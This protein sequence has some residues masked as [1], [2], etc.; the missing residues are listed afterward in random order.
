MVPR[1]SGAQCVR[2]SATGETFY[3][4]INCEAIPV[5]GD[6]IILRM[7]HL[8]T[9]VLATVER[10][11]VDGGIETRTIKGAEIVVT[12]GQITSGEILIDGKVSEATRSS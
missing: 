1:L 11:N 12:A 9:D 6:W 4:F 3:A 10:F 8:G 2:D 5:I 7:I